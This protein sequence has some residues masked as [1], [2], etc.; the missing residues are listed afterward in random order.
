MNKLDQSRL[1]AVLE[2]TLSALCRPR[3][4][5]S[6]SGW[7]D[8]TEAR[9]EIGAIVEQLRDGSV[10][11]RSALQISFLPTGPVQEVS[12]KSGWG[13]EFLS[14]ARRF[15]AEFNQISPKDGQL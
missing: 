10:P 1:I 13:K 14:L 8:Q 6:L 7:N 11:D 9:S 5:F 3:S 12:V 15:D 2:E 4:D